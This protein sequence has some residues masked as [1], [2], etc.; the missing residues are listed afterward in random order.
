[1]NKLIGTR[2]QR[3]ISLDNILDHIG[4]FAIGHRGPDQGADF[5]ISSAR[6]PIVI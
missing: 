5:G 4:D 2:A 1:M 3:Q 6:P